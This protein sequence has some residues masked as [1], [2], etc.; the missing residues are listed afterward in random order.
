MS[1]GKVILARSCWSVSLALVYDGPC[2]TNPGA[3]LALTTRSYSMML[4]ALP[5]SQL[6]TNHSM[7]GLEG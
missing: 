4:R 1:S 2:K 7:L 6:I 3:V 5:E